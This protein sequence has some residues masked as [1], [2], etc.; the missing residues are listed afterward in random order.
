MNA[1]SKALRSQVTSLERNL[2]AIEAVLVDVKR[3]S[4]RDVLRHPAGL[5]DTLVDLISVVSIADEAPTHQARQVSDEILARVEAELGKLHACVTHDL[6]A[7]NTALRQ[8]GL[9]V[10]G[11]P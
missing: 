7:L 9:E 6:G 5:D 4:P 2:S 10:L 11:L 1:A 3:E 8:A